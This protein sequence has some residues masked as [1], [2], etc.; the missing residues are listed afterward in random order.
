MSPLERLL[1][2]LKQTGVAFSEVRVELGAGGEAGP[3]SLPGDL[4]RELAVRWSADERPTRDRFE[5]ALGDADGETVLALS[6][7]SEVDPR[8]IAYLCRTA[9]S[10]AFLAND[11]S[12]R[13]AALRLEGRLEARPPANAGLFEIAEHALRIGAAKEF[14]AS[15]FDGYLP[16]LR[17]DLPAYALRVDDAASRDRTERFLFHA[18][19]KGSTDLLTRHVYPPLVW[20]LLRPLTRWRV[21]PNWITG[22]DW[23][24][25]LA[26]VPLFAGGAWLVGLS[27]AYAMSI[28]DSV[29]GKLAR[30]TYRHSRFGEFADHGL[31]VLHPPMW[32][33]AWAWWLGGGE[34]GSAPF[35]ASLW[36]LGC[37]TLDR[38]CTAVFRWRTGIS[39]HGFTRLDAT[40][41]TFISRRNINLPLFTVALLADWISPG[42]DFA[43]TT[44]YLIVAW[45]AA[46]LA[47]HGERLVRFWN[48]PAAA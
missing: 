23:I 42:H 14:A 28:L 26:V 10:V 27:L 16:M 11:G 4:V 2:G 33:M 3:R 41:R 1:R 15:D 6:A 43:R 35:Q 34:V 38:L 9:G 18:N 44:F 21:H 7:D 12:E 39:I 30:L 29:D 24:L 25:A 32:Y 31:D 5:T 48:A 17:R 37:Y 40:V 19:Y 46:S 20:A 45:Q 22:C 47:W 13:A 36:L 8:L